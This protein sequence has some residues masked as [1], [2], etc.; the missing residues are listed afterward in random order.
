MSKSNS[1][2]IALILVSLSLS[3]V[4]EQ[5]AKAET[6]QVQKQ[7]DATPFKSKNVV[8]PKEGSML[9]LEEMNRQINGDV[10]LMNL[11][12]MSKAHP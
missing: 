10:A 4:K 9:I 12:I 2:L 8:K 3:A 5:T 11:K 6:K 1:T 7:V